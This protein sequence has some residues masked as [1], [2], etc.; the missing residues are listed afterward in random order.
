M[1]SVIN[2]RSTRPRCAPN[3]RRTAS[4]RV[5]TV[6]RSSNRWATFTHASRRM[7]AVVPNTVHSAR[8]TPLTA[9]S[10]TDWTWS[11]LPASV[12]G[13]LSPIRRSMSFSARSACGAVTCVPSRATTRYPRM[14]RAVSQGLLPSALGI[15]TIEWS[16][17]HRSV[18]GVGKWKPAGM[19][20]MIV[21]ARRLMTS[22]FPRIPGS[23]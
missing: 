13:K 4:S 6:R 12:C 5:R 1:L 21:Y 7:S 3:A 11:S 10:R 23:P 18:S 8:E 19:T 14:P 9:S 22:D 20:P 2:C 15:V 17:D 16:V